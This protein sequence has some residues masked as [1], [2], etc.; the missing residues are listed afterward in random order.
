MNLEYIC[1]QMVR[2]LHGNITCISKSGAIEACYG[3]G[4]AVQSFI[5][6]FGI[7]ICCS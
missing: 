5:Y 4:G 6:K 2:I 7:S 1:E 3:H